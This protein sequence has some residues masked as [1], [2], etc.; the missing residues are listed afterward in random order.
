[1]QLFTKVYL[2]RQSIEEALIGQMFGRFLI[3]FTTHTS[4][5][6][7]HTTLDAKYFML[8]DVRVVVEE[9]IISRREECFGAVRIC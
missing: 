7:F 9:R 2:Y 6:N 5:K 3:R 4:N 1:M 8:A